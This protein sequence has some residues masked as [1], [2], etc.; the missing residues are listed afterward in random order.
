MV[1]LD[2]APRTGIA[3][4]VRR[5][6]VAGIE[7]VR[8]SIQDR[9]GRAG[10]PVYGPAHG[11]IGEYVQIAGEIAD[12]PVEHLDCAGRDRVHINAEC[13]RSNCVG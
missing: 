6:R 12:G 7:R 8:D 1:D 5:I 4:S 9:S 10:N 13:H 2:I 3:K 11:L